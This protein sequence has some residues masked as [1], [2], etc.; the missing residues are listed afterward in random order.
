MNS[1]STISRQSVMHFVADIDALAGDELAHLILGLPA[2]GAAVGL[3][4]L[5]GGRH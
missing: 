5:R 4:P 2:E 1:S 3:A